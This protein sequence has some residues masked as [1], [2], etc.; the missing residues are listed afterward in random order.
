MRTLIVSL[1]LLSL[2]SSTSYARSSGRSYGSHSY[3][4][5]SRSYS[6]HSY[7]AGSYHPHSYSYVP[8]SSHSYSPRTRSVTRYRSTVGVTRDSHGRIM[9]SAAAK[10]SF[11]RDH[12]CPANGHSSG[13]CPGYVT[14][15]GRWN[16]VGQMP[17]RTCSGR[18]LRQ[19]RRRTKRNGSVGSKT[20]IWRE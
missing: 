9:R 11:K 16:V 1:V 3:S 4:S 12:P 14:M 18:P 10:D 15:S 7:R 13:S 8:K 20:E 19:G 5:H 2:C 17:H 6:S